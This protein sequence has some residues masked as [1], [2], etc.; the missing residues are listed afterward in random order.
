MTGKLV[1]QMKMYKMDVV[2]AV[3][4]LVITVVRMALKTKKDI[5]VLQVF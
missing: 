4:I 5:A 1:A 3:F 2:F